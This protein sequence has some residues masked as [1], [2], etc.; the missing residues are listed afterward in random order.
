[1]I[2]KETLS[3][4]KTFKDPYQTEKDYLQ[5]LLLYSL[6]RASE[7]ELVFKGGTAIS[8]IYGSGRFSEDLDFVLA[9]GEAADG[10][11]AYVEKAISR[12]RLRYNTEYRLEKCRNMLKCSIKVK[13]PIY[14]AAPNEQAKQALGIDLNIYERPMRETRAIERVPIYD[15]LHPYAIRAE[16][17]EELLVD[18]AKAMLERIQPVA[19]DLYDAWFLSK[20][21]SI[22]LD[23]ELVSKK[24]GLYGKREGERFSI[25][26]L[27][28]SVKAI[29]RIWD[30]EMGR[31]ISH[32]PA[33]EEVRRDF[34]YVLGLAGSA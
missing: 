20:K 32:P 1:M 18:K 27:E 17:P 31:L 30:R 14:M 21:Y 34:R 4:Y 10:I 16:A 19:R 7:S 24:M 26:A 28:E 9:S 8:K 23:A 6:Y 11:G 12:I 5:D 2:D 3:S 22:K 25:S 13:G 33:Y 15:D 29:G